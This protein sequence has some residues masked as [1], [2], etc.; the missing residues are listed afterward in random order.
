MAYI[1]Q[2]KKKELQPLVKAILARYGL[3]G[4]LSINHHST[5]VLTIQ[6]GDIDFFGDCN[7]DRDGYMDV[8]NYWYHEHFTGRSLLF[9]DDILPVLNRGNHDNS[10]LMTDYFDVGWYVDIKIGKW[11][12]PYICNMIDSLLETV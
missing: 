3:K 4:S 7:F 2:D 12:K 11:D 9:L 5:L 6:S 1:N 8:N 10:D